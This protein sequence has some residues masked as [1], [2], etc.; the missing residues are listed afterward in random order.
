ML[1]NTIKNFAYQTS[2][3]IIAA[4]NQT[5]YKTTIHQFYQ[6]GNTLHHHYTDTHPVD[7][8]KTSVDNEFRETEPTLTL[9]DPIPYCVFEEAW[10]DDYLRNPIFIDGKSSYRRYLSPKTHLQKTVRHRIHLGM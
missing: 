1:D 4:L 6:L 8:C 7:C 9:D 3:R 10:I 5:D 2:I